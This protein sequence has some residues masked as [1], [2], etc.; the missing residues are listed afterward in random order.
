MNSDDESLDG[1]ELIPVRILGIYPYGDPNDARQR[2]ETFL[3]LLKGNEDI[4]TFVNRTFDRNKG[5]ESGSEQD[6][7][8]REAKKKEKE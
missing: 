1:K 6:K 4:L 7:K 2:F 8:Q 3:V 5:L